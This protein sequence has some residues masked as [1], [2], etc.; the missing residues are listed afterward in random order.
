MRKITYRAVYN[1]KKHLNASSKALLQVEA[2]LEGRKIYFSTHIYLSPQQWDKRKQ[3]IKEHPHASELN[4]MLKEFILNL[5]VKELELWKNGYEISLELLK[6][7]CTTLSSSSFISYVQEFVNASNIKET[8]RKNRLTTCSLLAMF[9]PHATFKDVNSRFVF[10]FER[11]LYNKNLQMNTVAKH[12]KHL[13]LFVNSSIDNGYLNAEDYA[14]KRY[15]IKTKEFKHA[16]LTR[17]EVNKLEQMNLINRHISLQHTLEAF[18]FCCYTGLRYSDFI[19]L[20]E[21]NVVEIDKKTWIVFRSV[22]TDVEVKL[23]LS[24]LFE[25]KPLIILKKHMRHLKNFF[26]L[27]SNSAVNKELIRI[28]K[29]ANIEKHFSFHSARHTNATLLMEKGANITTVQKLLGHRSISTTQIYSQILESTLVN[30][31][32]KCSQAKCK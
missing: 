32:K 8:T 1:R 21:D 7:K 29:L 25:G 31:L 12:M 3:L 19:N 13:R 10:E 2:Y 9:R 11:F 15:R 20:T 24:L 4:M 6:E 23:P 30:D 26:T 18:L 5:E 28:G 22:K 16:F 27:K 14:F 17:E